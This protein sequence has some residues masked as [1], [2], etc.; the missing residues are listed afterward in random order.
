MAA[1]GFWGG[2]RVKLTASAWLAMAAAATLM[3]FP[4]SVRAE[5]AP[6]I[7]TKKCELCH[8]IAGKGGKKAEVGGP[9]DGVGSKRDEAW[10]RKYIPDP[11]SAMDDAKMPKF[12][13]APADMDAVVKYMQSLK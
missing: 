3:A 4:A 9:L 8:T 10:L 2:R 1:C 11:K 13:L 7:Y 5:A 12:N 6:E